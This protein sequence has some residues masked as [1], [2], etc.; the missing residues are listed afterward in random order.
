MTTIDRYVAR[1]FLAGYLILMAVGI[2][3]YVV[4][5][6]LV[7]I[8]EFTEDQ[9]LGLSD[10]LWLMGD[11]YVCNL[12]LYYSQLGGPL[13]AIAAAF[14]LGMLLRNNEL[15]A[16]VAAGMPLQR[17]VV[18]LVLCSIVLVALWMANRELLMPQL[19]HK[20]ARNHDDIIVERT[21]GVPYARDDN[22]AILSAG[23]FHL[24]DNRLEDVYIIEPAERGR[25][26]VSAD[27]ATYNAQRGVWLLERG[28]RVTM[29]DPIDRQGLG[30][31]IQ[32][33]FIDE[34]PFTLTPEELLLRRNSEW[35]DLLSIR[36]L[37]V[38]LQSQQLPN[39]P[40]I[41]MSLHT[42][43]TQPLLQWTLLLLALPFFLIREPSNVM[44]AGGK[45]LLLAGAF[46]LVSFV[47]HSVVKE[48][49]YAALIAW[50]PI[51]LFGPLAVVQLANVKT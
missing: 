2:G 3:L 28:K 20:I 4:T 39:R 16:L 32:A 47:A 15:T 6:A 33:Q 37:N 44:A 29:Y 14:T 27:V 12:P 25:H 40:M 51:L 46:F 18:P 45:S 23:K 5:D 17:L 21:R 19:A 24:H 30:P 43:L 48:E 10:L 31:P 9:T 7:N 8:D 42:R 22:N 49:T 50:I 26:L 38:L 41:V 13:M 34:Y 35:A 1:T 36:Q 11:F